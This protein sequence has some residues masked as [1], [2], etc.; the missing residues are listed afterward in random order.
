MRR[1]TIHELYQRA[2][3]KSR[4]G[5]PAA[6]VDRRLAGAV[7]A[8]AA[9]LLLTDLSATDLW[10]PDEPRYAAVAEELRSFRHGAAGLALLHLN[11]E[12]Y[13]QKPPLYFWTAALAGVPGGRVTEVAARL[14]SALC[15]LATV[16]L[17]FAI[18]ALLR[19]RLPEAPSGRCDVPARHRRSARWCP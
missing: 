5:P 8:A 9:A 11:G 2:S 7:L 13:T 6:N 12:A 17:L 4:G 14:P 10:A 18:P 16:W 19:S 1:I 15:G 3:R